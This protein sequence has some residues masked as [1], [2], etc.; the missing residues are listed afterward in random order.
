MARKN[1]KRKRKSRNPQGRA[2]ESVGVKDKSNADKNALD[3]AR[4]ATS[5]TAVVDEPT[6]EAVD[7]V[8]FVPATID[9]ISA[10]QGDEP[11][12]SAATLDESGASSQSAE[13][14]RLRDSQKKTN[15][16]EPEA[17]SDELSEQLCESI[18]EQLDAMVKA[19]DEA[20]AE[21]ARAEQM[22][23]EA[24]ELI[25]DDL[26]LELPAPGEGHG[27]ASN[28]TLESTAD[29]VELG[30]CVDQQ[31]AADEEVR[32]E[33]AVVEEVAFEH[34]A[35]EEAAAKE[36]VAEELAVDEL[37]Q[38]LLAQAEADVVRVAAD[39]SQP[40][41][42]IIAANTAVL[43]QVVQHIEL[44]HQTRSVEAPVDQDQL[45]ANADLM[46]ELQRTSEQVENLYQQ[47]ADAD[48]KQI[49]LQ[50]QLDDAWS[51]NDQLAEELSQ[52]KANRGSEQVTSGPDPTNAGVMTWEQRKEQM[53]QQMEDDSF[54][55]ESF[56]ESLQ[57]E[58][59]SEFVDNDEELSPVE[60]VSRL[61]DE[62]QRM[63]DEL[64]TRD[65]EVQELHAQLTLAKNSTQSGIEQGTVAIED[66]VDVDALIRDE[67]E[68]L[69]Q[70]QREWEERFRETEIAASLERARLSRERREL[71][72]QNTELE[73][74]LIHHRRETEADLKS[75]GKGKR[76]WLAMLGLAE[77]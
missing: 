12:Q 51:R 10:D 27:I 5:A 8:P 76:R 36:S 63:R 50:Q 61:N 23:P 44:M 15:D 70:Q 49:D 47:V 69:Q 14:N 43:Q 33:E 39:S 56:V 24:P 72:R 4:L 37:A 41:G 54:D 48:Q 55:A 21:Q 7:A 45:R 46:E 29:E 73:E 40:I 32:A 25:N 38:S 3:L 42:D 2:A 58:P 17:A 34:V 62:L 57:S 59:D 6:R 53:L 18:N 74:Q 31:V 22:Q 60:Y 28:D 77:D 11:N 30:R 20:V 16:T 19:V 64:T 67:R 35:F 65:Q 66:L 75:G 1:R 71:A 52:A 68:Q 26:V 13:R 9:Q